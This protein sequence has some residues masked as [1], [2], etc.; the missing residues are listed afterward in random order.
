VHCDQLRTAVSNFHGRRHVAVMKSGQVTQL[1]VHVPLHERPGDLHLSDYGWRHS[2]CGGSDDSSLSPT[3]Q[4]RLP[5]MW[6]S[7]SPFRD[8]DLPKSVV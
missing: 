3:N 5:A 8:A 7:Q 2:S 1:V 4:L 6:V